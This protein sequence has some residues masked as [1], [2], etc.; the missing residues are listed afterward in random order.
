MNAKNWELLSQ[1]GTPKR[2]KT[3]AQY[4][5]IYAVTHRKYNIRISTAPHLAE[6][7]NIYAS[8]ISHTQACICIRSSAYTIMYSFLWWTWLPTNTYNP[9]HRIISINIILPLNPPKKSTSLAIRTQ[10]IGSV[11]T[12][13]FLPFQ[14]S[15][16]IKH[17]T[18][19]KRSHFLPS[20]KHKP[21]RYNQIKM[22]T[23]PT[24]IIMRKIKE[25]VR[26]EASS[27][28][29]L[30]PDL[31]TLSSSNRRN[32]NMSSQEEIPVDQES[33]AECSI[34]GAGD[35]GHSGALT[36]E[37]GGLHSLHCL[38]LTFFFSN[39]LILF[40]THFLN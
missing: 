39:P 5:R 12:I 4:L 13:L 26:D 21:R 17:L 32:I 8:V 29:I 7:A 24:T 35:C 25:P 14:K 6:G 30:E 11:Q 9:N 37:N 40:N 36:G 16:S 33:G 23:S 34:A 28:A 27:D 31:R 3:N 18:S 38:S 22:S 2:T 19:I 15:I 20:N 1:L 10:T